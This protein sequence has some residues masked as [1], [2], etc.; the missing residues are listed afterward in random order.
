MEFK[1]GLL[2][3]LYLF[4]PL[5]FYA[6]AELI[7]NDVL[8]KE[9]LETATQKLNEISE[10]LTLIDVDT[11]SFPLAKA[12]EAHIVCLNLKT[13]KGIISKAVFTFSD[14][15]LTYIEARGNVYKVFA[16]SRTDTARSYM[17]YDVYVADKLF[18][19]KAQDA[20][21]IMTEGAMHTNLFAWKNPYLSPSDLTDSVANNSSRIPTFL[22]MG[23]SLDE[24]K[25]L[26]DANS[27]FTY[28]EELDG[29]D[30]DAQ[31]QINCFGVSYLGFPRKIEA[32]FGDNKLSVVWILTAKG[33]ED[34]IR[35]A[36][37]KEF[38]PPIFINNDWEIFNNWQVGLR[39]DK[40][41][42]LLIEQQIGLRYKTSFFKQ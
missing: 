8:L 34:R 40:P 9:S 27:E 2:F 31:I 10:T 35:K 20:A 4:L 5:V 39:K 13:P 7:F 23:S 36:L 16:S 14:D 42:V 26:L 32:R 41:E 28:T 30:P 12:K 22:K 33:E 19:N 6:Q 37:V 24:L 18:L 1:K 21:R 11:P 3:S 38:G 15:S 25:P 17:D 29:T